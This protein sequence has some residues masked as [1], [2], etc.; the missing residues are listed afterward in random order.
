MDAELEELIGNLDFVFEDG[1]LKF[2][3][4][5]KTSCDS[6]QKD[7]DSNEASP[8]DSTDSWIDCAPPSVISKGST[9][10]STRKASISEIR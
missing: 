10:G 2:V 3:N 5:S 8:A 7:A 9:T 6:Q 4:K 1:A